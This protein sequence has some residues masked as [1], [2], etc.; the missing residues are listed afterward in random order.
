MRLAPLSVGRDLHSFVKVVGA[1]DEETRY[2]TPAESQSKK[3]IQEELLWPRETENVVRQRHLKLSYF[4]N[5]FD[6]VAGSGLAACAPV[7]VFLQNLYRQ[8]IAS[9]NGF[10]KSMR[11]EAWNGANLRRFRTVS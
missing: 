1:C 2:Q 6:S 8:A 11:C 3:L 7:A 9:R 5:F 10:E 4:Q